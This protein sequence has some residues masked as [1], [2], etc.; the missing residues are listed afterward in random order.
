MFSATPNTIETSSAPRMFSPEQRVGDEAA[1]EA[2]E[3]DGLG[4]GLGQAPGVEG[5]RVDV[6][7]GSRPEDVGH[8]QADDHR[9][10][11]QHEEIA[12]GL[13]A[14]PAGLAQVVH[15]GDAGDDDAEHDRDDDHPYEGDE[16]VVQRPQRD[17]DLGQQEADRDAQD[18]ADDDLEPQLAQEPAEPGPLTA[19]RRSGGG[20][21]R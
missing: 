1:D 3:G 6:H 4:G 8:D 20:R 21:H 16:P 19:V 12:D 7:P 18:G 10:E 9:D 5:G 2:G 11:R 14:D 13:D 15:R 17:A